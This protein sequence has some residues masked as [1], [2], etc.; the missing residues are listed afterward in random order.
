MKKQMIII[1]IA[2]IMMN[3]IV[4]TADDNEYIKMNA[5]KIIKKY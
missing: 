5:F 1:K 3:K 4:K 2:Y